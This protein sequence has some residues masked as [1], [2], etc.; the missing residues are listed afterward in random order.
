[1]KK[2]LVVLLLLITFPITVQ[3]DI[4]GSSNLQIGGTGSFDGN[5]E[6]RGFISGSQLISSGDVFVD[7]DTNVKDLG[8]VDTVYYVSLDGDDD[9]N[10]RTLENAV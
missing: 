5:L 8:K 7:Q 10:G 4:S 2:I 6:V 1:M 3:Q 9:N